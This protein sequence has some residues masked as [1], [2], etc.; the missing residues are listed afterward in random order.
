MDK[1]DHE[2][3][4]IDESFDHEYGTEV[5]QFM[6]CIICGATSDDDSD[7]KEPDIEVP[8]GYFDEQ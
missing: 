7:I 8:D 6:Q 4:L 5:I 1:C 2:L 3:E